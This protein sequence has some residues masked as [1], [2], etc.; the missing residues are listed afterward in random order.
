V[1]NTTI[2]HIYQGDSQN[3]DISRVGNDSEFDVHIR[4]SKGEMVTVKIKKSD[5]GYLGPQ[6]EFYPEFP[7]IAQLKEMYTK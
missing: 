6:G 2:N 1:S 4:N 5:N 7:K 3:D